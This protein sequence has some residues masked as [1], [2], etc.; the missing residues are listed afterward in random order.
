M[1]INLKPPNTTVYPPFKN[2]LYMEEYFDR[3]WKNEN[4]QDKDKFVYLDIYWLNLFITHGM[5]PQRIIPHI[6]DY[7]ISI[8]NKALE[9]NKIVF[10]ICQ[11]DD[12]LCMGDKKPKN[13]IVF[14]IGQ[15]VDVP[16]PL[17]VEDRNN[18]LR[19][20]PR[21][22]LSE[23]TTLASF[24]GTTTHPLRNIMITAL[25]NQP[26]FYISSKADWHISVPSD[27][28]NL[29]VNKTRQ[30]RFGLAPRG[31]GPSS[32]RF[33]EIM[34]LGIIPVY[35]HDDDNALPYRDI[36]DYS[37][38]S[39]L[40]HINNIHT[41]PQILRNID[42]IKYNEM[43]KELNRVSLW[44]APDGMCIYIKQWLMNKLYYNRPT[45][46]LVITTYNRFDTFLSSQLDKY[47][48]NKYIDE[49]IVSDD[50]SD[51]YD[52]LIQ[53]KN[54]KSSDKLK[55]YRQPQN[56]KALK[57]K[58]T[59]CTYATKEWICLMDSDNFCNESYFETLFNDWNTNGIDINTIY[60]PSKGLPSFNHSKYI[61]IY[62]K[63]NWNQLYN[64]GTQII[65]VGNNIFHN[66]IVKYLTPC[67][68]EDIEP[69]AVD[70]LY[71]LYISIKNGVK[72]KVL[73]GMYYYHPVHDGSYYLK[74]A[75]E[76]TKF[77]NSFNWL[78]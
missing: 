54:T 46:S 71:I 24:I 28:V 66:Y 70:A 16:L 33:F 21:S 5:E 17:I 52:K 36:L 67:L 4:F 27:L 61:G 25:Q 11:W 22:D 59:A 34:Q 69:Y 2:G 60:S 19:H 1:N 35:I 14:S 53:Y 48:E 39:I 41:L 77:Q 64:P 32:F 29:F 6:T 8:C 57:N 40:I 10:T 51:D 38:F 68:N 37:K 76:A 62:D 3:F 23:R 47:L 31:Y 56:L 42:D 13:L 63:N 75:D 49:I 20:I 7:I 55:I 65:N 45:I 50:C 12:G 44:F 15:S 30:S 18:T 78:L 58:I 9:E 43:L 72:F 73:D 26:D 74:T